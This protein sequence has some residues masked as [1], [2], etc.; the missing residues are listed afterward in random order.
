MERAEQ[1]RALP[2]CAQGIGW[3]CSLPFWAW[4]VTPDEYWSGP[5]GA[6]LA[7]TVWG[8]DRWYENHLKTGLRDWALEVFD[9]Y[10]HRPHFGRGSEYWKREGKDFP[11][12]FRWLVGN[13]YV[14]TEEDSCPEGGIEAGMV[15]A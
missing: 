4:T 6:Q 11:R 10:G 1:W 15:P 2:D 5:A 14:L 7:W 9:K 13:S 8:D 3:G 12:K